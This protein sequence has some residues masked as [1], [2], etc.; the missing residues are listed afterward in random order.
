[1]PASAGVT[2]SVDYELDPVGG[3]RG[4]GLAG[5]GDQPEC[6]PPGE[7]ASGGRL[8]AIPRAMT[9]PLVRGSTSG[10]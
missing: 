7:P 6:L 8:A 10:R 3:L 1:M 2:D 4:S 9:S 5:R